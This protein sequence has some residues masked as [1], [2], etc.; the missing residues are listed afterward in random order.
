MGENKATYNS[1]SGPTLPSQLPGPLPIHSASRAPSALSTPS[2]APDWQQYGSARSPSL[3]E[4]TEADYPNRV[5][6]SMLEGQL[7]APQMP[8][9]PPPSIPVAPPQMSG[10]NAP[11]GSRLPDPAAPP[12]SHFYAASNPHPPHGDALQQHNPPSAMAYAAGPRTMPDTSVPSEKGAGEYP[13]F[14]TTQQQQYHP[15]MNRPQGNQPQ[16]SYPWYNQS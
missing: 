9:Q 13:V 7:Q 14:Q 6:S 11:G 1:P 2:L 8:P 5:E 16:Y 15:A 3:C 12:Y 10:F 4:S